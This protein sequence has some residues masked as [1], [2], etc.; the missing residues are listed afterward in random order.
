MYNFR[1]DLADERR[2]LYK[3]ANKIENEV[4][5][6]E[7]SNEQIGE[8]LSV[9]RVKITNENG[10]KAIGKP[11]GEYI[12]IDIKKINLLTDEEKDQAANTLANELKKMIGEKI[13]FKDE[14]LVVGLGNEEVTP[15]ALGPN[16]TKEIEVTRH[17]L[18]Y[19]PQ[20]I[21]EN[22]R[23][24]SAIAPG[25]L[26]TTGIETVEIVKGVV[27]NT[28]PKL[29]IAIDALSSRSM[30]RIS[31]SIQLSNTGIVPG[32]G[33]GNKRDEISQNSLGIPVIAIG[34]PT[35]V[36]T[37]VVVNDALNIFIEK[38]QNDAKSN[39]YLNNLKEQDN[40]EQIKEALIPKNFNFVVTPKEIDELVLGMSKII[41]EGINKAL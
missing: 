20:Y 4:D 17:I 26:G 39:D 3:K 14:I 30:E 16:V 35:V 29:L 7:S 2:D 25:V 12:T 19:L 37:A 18:K 9:S 1:T 22:T 10:E 6:I 24:V 31:S 32:A 41:A 27:E 5:G 21:D 28:K 38:L 34:I 33:V 36:E 40:Y 13:Q 8:K 23:P 15:D 11:Q